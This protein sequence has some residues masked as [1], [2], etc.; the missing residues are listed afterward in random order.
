MGKEPEVGGAGREEGEVGG[1]IGVPSEWSACDVENEV[2]GESVEGDALEELCQQHRCEGEVSASTRAREQVDGR[3][4]IRP[5]Q[6]RVSLAQLC[7]R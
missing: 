7:R 3:T 1:W 5:V 4:R 6:Q 2:P